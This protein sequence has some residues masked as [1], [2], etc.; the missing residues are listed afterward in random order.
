MSSVNFRISLWCIVFVVSVIGIGLCWPLVS[1]RD[2]NYA[3]KTFQHVGQTISSPVPAPPLPGSEDWVLVAAWDLPVGTRIE[4]SLFDRQYRWELKPTTE[5]PADALREPEAM[6]GKRLVRKLRRGE[7]I[8]ARDLSK[9]VVALIPPGK[10][11]LS[12]KI[13]EPKAHHGFIAPGSH[14]DLVMTIPENGES[15]SRIA[16][17][18][19]LV[20]A[21]DVQAIAPNLEGVVPQFVFTLVVS[22]G[23]AAIVGSIVD[24]GLAYNLVLQQEP[25]KPATGYDEEKIVEALQKVR[26]ERKSK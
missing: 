12:L 16:L 13:P 9:G 2:P 15:K 11:V 26:A 20:V 6:I 24:L 8:L 18:N 23:E 3:A 25:S 7:A 4:R 19:I 14:V 22:K 21:V 5:I 17:T 10:S 1:T